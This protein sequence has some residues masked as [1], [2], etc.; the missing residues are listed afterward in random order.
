M[1]YNVYLPDPPESVYRLITVP[2][3][4]TDSFKSAFERGVRRRWPSE[5]AALHRG[6]STRRALRQAAKYA[7]VMNQG[8]EVVRGQLP[9]IASI[10]QIEVD[11]AR[12]QAMART[13]KSRGHYTVWAEADQLTVIRIVSVAEA[14]AQD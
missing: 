1:A 3:T 4:I 7:A 9:P 2:G 8:H 13:L 14:L 11:G 10:A 5:D 12:G 6:I